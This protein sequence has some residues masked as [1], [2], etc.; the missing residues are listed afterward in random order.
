M[1]LTITALLLAICIMAPG[2]VLLLSDKEK[3]L[4][5]PRER[6]IGS[7]LTLASFY[8]AGSQGYT[9]LKEDFT[10]IAKSLP[11]IL[12]V[13]A[14][15]SCFLMDYLFT[16]GLGF[17]ICL[18]GTHYLNLLFAANP[19]ARQLGSLAAYVGIIVGMFL[20]GHPW[21]LRKGIE[22]CRNEAKWKKILPAAFA[23]TAILIVM[24]PLNK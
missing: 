14:L 3:A 12:P 15:A 20:I 5:I 1:T 22:M 21:M 19:S 11:Y 2:V 10:I 24:I 16:R 4:S 13:L 18:L 9:L 23:I 17:V 8:W 7:L 6:I